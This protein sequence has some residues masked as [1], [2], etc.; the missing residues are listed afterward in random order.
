M[1]RKPNRF[2]GVFFENFFPRSH[3]L[4]PDESIFEKQRNVQTF[5]V[6]IRL[7]S[8]SE[9]FAPGPSRNFTTGELE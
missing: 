9:Y 5:L 1:R 2:V 3:S 6:A 4:V 7:I 8:E